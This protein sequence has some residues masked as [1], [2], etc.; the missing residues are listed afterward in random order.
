MAGP[1]QA[2]V[3]AL[4]ILQGNMILT[5]SWSAQIGP[6]GLNTPGLGHTLLIEPGTLSQPALYSLRPPASRATLAKGHV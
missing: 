5:G 1:S 4:A 3:F 2:A 6:S